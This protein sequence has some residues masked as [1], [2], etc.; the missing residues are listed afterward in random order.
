MSLKTKQVAVIRTVRNQQ[1]TGCFDVPYSDDENV[2][3][4]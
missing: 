1:E 2:G 4:V 3:L